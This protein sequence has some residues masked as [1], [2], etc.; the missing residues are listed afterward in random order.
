MLGGHKMG[1]LQEVFSTGEGGCDSAGDGCVVCVGSFGLVATDI[2]RRR[3]AAF[4]AIVFGTASAGLRVFS[5]VCK[6]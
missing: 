2:P 1:A 6:Q 4:L 5:S 3:L